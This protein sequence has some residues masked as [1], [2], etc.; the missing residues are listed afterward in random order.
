MKSFREFLNEITTVKYQKDIGADVKSTGRGDNTPYKQIK[1][2]SLHPNKLKTN[3]PASKTAKETSTPESETKIQSLMKSHRQGKK[4]FET[5]PILV[6]RESD[7]S[8]TVLDG[9]HRVEAAR[10]LGITHLHMHV[11]PNNQTKPH[12]FE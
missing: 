10:R 11:L 1:L 9:H 6:K 5:T 8:H 12:E 4:P 2:V 7:G 3:E